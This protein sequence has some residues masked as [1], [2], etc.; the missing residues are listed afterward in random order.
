MKYILILTQ[1]VNNKSVEMLAKSLREKSYDDYTI[2][3]FD[4]KCTQ[5]AGDYVLHKPGSN[6]FSVQSIFIADIA[7]VTKRTWGPIRTIALQ[8]CQQLEKNNV[9]I[10]N[11]CQ[12][13]Q[14]SHSKILQ[15]H[16]LPAL[17]PHT[18]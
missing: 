1:E 3:I 7:L 9:L 6:N 2:L 12:F 13:I 18:V 10:L 14:W 16:T 5:I 15:Y 8:L 17:F 4:V 11:G